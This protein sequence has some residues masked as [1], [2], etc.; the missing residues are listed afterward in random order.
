MADLLRKPH[1]LWVL[2]AAVIPIIPLIVLARMEP[3]LP[4][5]EAVVS[6]EETPESPQQED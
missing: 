1:A 6:Q 3:T 5:S 2:L 4:V